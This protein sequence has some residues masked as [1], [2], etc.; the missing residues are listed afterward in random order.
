MS[1]P[2]REDAGVGIDDLLRHDEEEPA[3]RARRRLPRRGG[4]VRHLFVVAAC[5]VATVAALNAAG[6]R[7]SAVLVFA[8][9]AALRALHRLTGRVAAPAPTRV[10]ERPPTG[11]EDGLYHWQ[12]GDALRAAVRRW[13]DHLHWATADG[14]RFSRNVLPVLAEL[15]DERL[16]QRHGITR[17]SDPRRA[18]QLLGEPLWRVLTDPGR[19]PP[20]A[21]DLAAYVT[22]LENL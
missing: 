22:S 21:R 12:G 10:A 14:A 20:K 6:L 1:Y 5:T 9:F 3:P 11:A 18:R 2:E 19:R 7:V 4:W 13:E 16:R 15:V 8:G 17:A